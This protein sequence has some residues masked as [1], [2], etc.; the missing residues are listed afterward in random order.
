ML[1]GT[2]AG[3]AGRRMLALAAVRQHECSSMSEMQW[4]AAIGLWAL[5]TC[6]RRRLVTAAA[7]A[8]HPPLLPAHRPMRHLAAGPDVDASPAAA[9]A[10]GSGS[11]V[12]SLIDG[13]DHS[14]EVADEPEPQPKRERKSGP[15]PTQSSCSSSR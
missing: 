13:G 12:P 1:A 15:D 10:D 5:L 8:Q 3:A 14:D 2:A 7:G 4:L 6:I 9:T 11:D